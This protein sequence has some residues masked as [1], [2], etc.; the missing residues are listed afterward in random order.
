MIVSCD[1]ARLY[2]NV[3]IVEITIDH[4][5]VRVRDVIA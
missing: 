3:A 1:V 4:D 5:R 2:T